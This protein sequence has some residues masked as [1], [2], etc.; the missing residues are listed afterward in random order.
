MVFGLQLY[1]LYSLYLHYDIT[2][3]PQVGLIGVIYIVCRVVGKVAGA[4]IGAVIMKAPDTV[5]KH[6]SFSL[7]PQEG[8]AIGLSLLA[9]QLLPEYGQTIRA[10]VLSAIF[11]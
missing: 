1:I 2:V 3:L 6:I 8:V 9:A 10:V 4:S 11:I 5:K 7:V